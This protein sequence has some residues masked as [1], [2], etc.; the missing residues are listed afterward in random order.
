[1]KYQFMERYGSGFEVKKMCL[2][3]GVNRSGYYAYLRRGISHREEENIRL[4][5]L[6]LEVWQRSHGVY[7]SPRINADLH[8]LGIRCGENRVA[9]I[10]RE[11]G[12]K[13]R[14]RKQFKVTT[15]SSAGQTVFANL[16]RRNF[17]VDLAGKVWV[18]DIS[19]LQ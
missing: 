15:K 8:S 17:T 5:L 7:G 18:S 3:F 10:M 9:R 19:V 2:V 12:I 4:L 1:M 14:T 6:I 16:L 11:A 13:A